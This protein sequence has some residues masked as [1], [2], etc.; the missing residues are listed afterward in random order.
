MHKNIYL[1]FSFTFF[2]C[3]AWSGVDVSSVQNAND[4]SS[5]SFADVYS[6]KKSS[7]CEM[8]S[9]SNAPILLIVWA[10]YCPP[11]LEKL[12]SV[13]RLEGALKLRKAKTKVL[14]LAIGSKRPYEDRSIENAP[15]PLY[16]SENLLSFMTDVGVR[17]IPCAFLISRQGTVV[18]KITAIKGQWDSADIL[19]DIQQF[20]KDKK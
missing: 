9:Q 19:N 15:D 2:L 8:L 7:I 3:C 17:F 14:V 4:F 13:K 12:A 5:V 20:E 6:G 18:K 1:A 11:C 16:W 10:S